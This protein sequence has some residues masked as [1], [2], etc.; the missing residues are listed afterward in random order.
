MNKSALSAH[1]AAEAADTRATADSVVYALLAAIAASTTTP[2]KAGMTFRDTV[3]V[4]Q[5]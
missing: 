1:V 5:D 4:R 3:N 2:V